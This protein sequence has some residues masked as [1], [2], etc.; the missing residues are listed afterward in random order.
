MSSYPLRRSLVAFVTMAAMSSV[1][2][3]APHAPRSVTD[4]LNGTIGVLGRRTS[5]TKDLSTAFDKGGDYG[6]DDCDDD[7]EFLWPSSHT[8]CLAKGKTSRRD[9][10][11]NAD[12]DK[13][14]NHDNKKYDGDCLLSLSFFI[15]VEEREVCKPKDKAHSYDY[16]C[17]LELVFK[18]DIEIDID[19]EKKKYLDEREK[20]RHWPTR[21]SDCADIDKLG[22]T[23]STVGPDGENYDDDCMMQL[24]LRLEKKQKDSCRQKATGSYGYDSECM[25]GLCMDLDVDVEFDV[26][27]DYGSD[28]MQ[29]RAH[30]NHAQQTDAQDSNASVDS[31]ASSVNENAVNRISENAINPASTNV[32]N[33]AAVAPNTGSGSWGNILGIDLIKGLNTVKRSY[34][35]HY[36]GEHEDG[37]G[38][39]EEYGDDN[40]DDDDNEDED[41]QYGNEGED[42]EYGDDNEDDDDNEDEDEH[43]GGEG[44]Y[45]GDEDDDDEDDEDAGA[46]YAGAD[47]SSTQASSTQ[48]DAAAANERPCVVGMDGDN[49]CLMN[50]GALW[51]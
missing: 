28:D 37:E 11:Q 49:G 6:D 3:A 48:V 39:D 45:N 8:D 44:E 43:Y 51:R 22:W 13:W 29:K 36:G 7:K 25:I 42:E 31:A 1:V 47:A 27:V 20:K 30:R 15:E 14:Y 34:R 12:F 19:E 5:T 10:S 32:V 24:S 26:D 16:Q 50:M 40:E 38:E 18:V 2:L 46:E 23:P 33:T 21:K 9:Y 17:L 4:A 41:E 35:F